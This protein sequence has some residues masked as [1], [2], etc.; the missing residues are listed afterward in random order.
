VFEEKAL[1][2]SQIS[3]RPSLLNMKKAHDFPLDTT[4]KPV[5]LI[6]KKSKT[7]ENTLDG[8]MFDVLNAQISS[9][10]WEE[11]GNNFS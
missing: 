7:I 4:Y 10:K 6:G 2:K 11:E 1:L 3:N 8:Q 5:Q 9:R